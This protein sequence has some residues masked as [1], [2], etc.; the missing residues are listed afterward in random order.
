VKARVIWI[1]V[2]A[3]IA[4]ALVFTYAAAGGTDYKP[5]ATPDPCLPRHW[6]KVSG[7]TAIGEQIALSAISGAACKLHVSGEEL[8]LAFTSQKRLDQ[9]GKDNGLSK[10]Q[11][12]NAARDGLLR[13]IDEGS[14][15]GAINGLEAFGLRLIAQTTPIDRLIEYVRSSFGG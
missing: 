8:A 5:S 6:P 14:K 13:G 3:A 9:F 7:T 2:A 4:A 15:S 1:A 11:I 10:N 12:Q